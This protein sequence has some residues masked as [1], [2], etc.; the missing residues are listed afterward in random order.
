MSNIHEIPTYHILTYGC[1]MN[2]HDSEV[3]AGIL[4]DMGYEPNPTIEDADVILMNTCCVRES[5]EDKIYGK[6]GSLKVLKEQ[7]PNLIIG[8]CG[9]MA[10]KPNEESR[11]RRIAPHVDFILG[12]DS[13]D[14][15]PDMIRH[16][17]D[18]KNPEVFIAEDEYHL[19]APSLPRA[20]K[21]SHHA[22]VVIMH[23]CDNFC[24][25]CI[26]P[27]VRG[28]E[29][30][31]NPNDI[32]REI[33]GLA[34]SGIREI[35]LLGQNVNSYGFGLEEKIDFSDLLNRID[36][37]TDIQRI[38]FMTSHPKDLS[39]KLIDTIAQAR[40]VC[41]HI[42]L[43]I[44]SGSTRILERMNRKY[45]REDY[46]E[47][48]HRIR[49]TIPSCSITTD[50]IVGFP[51]ETDEDFK[52]T[53]DMVQK[54]RWDAAYT[55]LY[56]HRSGTAA[57]AMNNSIATAV[58]KQRLQELMDVQNTISF[59][60]HQGMVGSTYEVM[61]EGPSKTN[62][63]VWAART[64]SN[65]LVLLPKSKIIRNLIPGD[66]CVATILEAKTWT[67]HGAAVEI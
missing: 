30:S 34:A 23:G 14:Q 12:S 56:S 7:N 2:E 4:Q 27:Y 52:D 13:M 60:I 32:L 61:L 36:R 35:T 8:I 45:S 5:A 48:V 43:P 57:A 17:H 16:A 55:F 46:I 1:Q 67:L 42:H 25:Y 41:N 53:M 28:R 58:K 37:E 11:I 63:E 22:W 31:R 66:T 49:K 62:Q 3:L 39:D 51:G 10:Q 15:L 18:S 29:R 20:G 33:N 24:T 47:L 40:H 44:Q 6:M 26:V 38:R 50:I 9:C 21:S 59:E 54:I 19:P 65:H 64:T